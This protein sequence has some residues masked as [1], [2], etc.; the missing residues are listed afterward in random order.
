MEIRS[1]WFVACRAEWIMMV[2]HVIEILEK[3]RSY[4]GENMNPI[5]EML[6]LNYFWDIQVT[7]SSE[8][9]N[10]GTGA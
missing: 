1:S 10:I 2:F 7:V 9:L 3:I 8:Q 5:L 4:K 6:S